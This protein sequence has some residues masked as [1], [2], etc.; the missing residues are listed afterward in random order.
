MTPAQSAALLPSVLAPFGIVA[1]GALVVLLCEVFLARRRSFVGRPVTREWIGTVLAGVS[2][3]FLFIALVVSMQFFVSLPAQRLVFDPANPMVAMDHLTAFSAALICIV[4]IFTCWLSASYLVELGINHGEYYALL[5]LASSGMILTVQAV[6]LM[7]LFLGIELMSI[8]IYAMAGFIR[9]SLESNEAALKYFLIG[10][11][12]SA[13][14][15]YGMALLYGTTGHTDFERIRGA[16]D[17]TNPIALAG[18][19]FLVVGFGFKVAAVP[20]HQWTPDVYEG[21]PTP[22][23]SYMAAGVKVAAFVA[24][25]RLVA[26]A[27]GPL[28][29]RLSDLF[30]ALSAASVIVGNVMAVIQDNVKRML[31][32]SSVAN[33]GY[34]LIGF[35][36]GTPAAHQAIL[37]FLLVYLFMNVGAFAVVIALANGG[38]DR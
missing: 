28:D 18:L 14:L 29:A 37:Y 16:F 32:Y 6:D 17:A 30:W 2:S 10:S 19:G 8:P 31:A 7:T 25:L 24:L 12:T 38:R 9:R 1:C 34:I 26:T 23:T 5:L 36:V 3:L 33:A 35:A 20:F 13:I 27:F 15:L 21:A 4:A 22:I 11:F